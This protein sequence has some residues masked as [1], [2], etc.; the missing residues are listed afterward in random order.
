MFKLTVIW[1]CIFIPC[2]FRPNFT[3]I[4]QGLNRLLAVAMSAEPNF[5]S[6]DENFY[7]LLQSERFQVVGL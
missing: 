2:P 1:W 3:L 6:L 5:S 7:Q 4:E